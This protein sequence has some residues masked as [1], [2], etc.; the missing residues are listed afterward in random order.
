MPM[1]QRFA[2]RLAA[3]GLLADPRARAPMHR[4]RAAGTV[5]E[6]SARLAGDLERQGAAICVNAEAWSAC[7]R[8]ARLL[9]FVSSH[10]TP[11]AALA[12]AAD[13]LTLPWKVLVKEDAEGAVWIQWQDPGEAPSARAA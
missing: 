9:V 4:L 3:L 1:S 11:R 12:D 10:W 5:E 7:G 6:V 13:G 2:E 8:P